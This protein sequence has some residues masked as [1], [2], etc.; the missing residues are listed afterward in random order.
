M[1][2]WKSINTAPR[3]GSVVDLWHRDDFA[4]YETWWDDD[5][6]VSMLLGDEYFTHWKSST[7]GPV[8]K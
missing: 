6:W 8:V 1:D 2:D 3:D 5:C 7:V 4:I